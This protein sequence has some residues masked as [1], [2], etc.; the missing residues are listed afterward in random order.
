MKTL[1]ILFAI[2]ALFLMPNVQAKKGDNGNLRLLYWN[3]QNGMWDGQTD[4]YQR[5]TS[6]VQAQKPDICVWCEAQKLYVTGT[7]KYEVESEEECIARWKRLAERYGHKYV[8]LSAHRDNYPQ[9]Y[10][11]NIPLEVEK[12]IVGNKDTVV[13][14]GASWYKA[15]IGKKTLN[16]VSLH[17][18]PMPYAFNIPTAER[19]Q[20]KKEHGGD[21]YRQIEM[22][23]ICQ[24]TILTRKKARKEYWAMMGDFNAVSRVDNTLYG[25]PEDATAFLVHDYI[26]EETPYKD[27]LKEFYPDSV[28]STT[29]GSKRIDFIYTTPALLKKATHATI[30]RDGYPVPVRNAEKISNFWHPSDHSPIIADFKGLF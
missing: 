10:T 17:T 8:Y 5:F 13:C 19:E 1:H 11:S 15:R 6:W 20:S 24:E 12:L 9:I 30:V 14:H 23:Y 25:Y 7:A 16:L 3:V 18:W 26:M 29:G 28:I 4:D 21:K 27:L 22:K 2:A